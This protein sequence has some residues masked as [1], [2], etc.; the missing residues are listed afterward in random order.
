MNTVRLEN[1]FHPSDFSEGDIPAFAHALR[2][3]LAAK[4]S[5]SLLHAS[6][7]GENVHWSDFPSVRRVLEDWRLL[8]R[9]ASH[10]D[11][12]QLGLEVKKV[13][14]HGADPAVAIAEYA[15]AHAAD[16][17]VLATH[18][19]RGVD[20]LLHPSIALASAEASRVMTLFVP[21]QSKGFVCRESG[22]LRLRRVLI[23]VDRSPD[24]KAAVA[25]TL[26]LARLLSILEMHLTFLHVGKPELAPEI[27]VPERSGLT[28]EMNVWEGEVVDHILESSRAQEADLIVMPTRARHGLLGA[29][30]GSTTARVLR[31]APCP[32][33]AVPAA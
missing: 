18:Q 27:Q 28:H 6:N 12:E 15:R 7:P 8:P 19:R 20:R 31:E 2:I 21:R 16:L 9:G 13:K 26:A 25:A 24:P 3:A 30:R 29:I 33:L 10:A 17:L 23:P 32:V 22:A 11:L 5:L 1:V 14:K 4:G